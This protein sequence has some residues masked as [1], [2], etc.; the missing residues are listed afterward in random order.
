MQYALNLYNLVARASQRSSTSKQARTQRALVQCIFI[1]H[2]LVICC[3][4]NSPKST[5]IP[6]FQHPFLSSYRHF[7]YS[8]G[9]LLSFSLSRDPLLLICFVWFSQFSSFSLRLCVDLCVAQ[10][11]KKELNKYK[12]GVQQM[13]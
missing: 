5:M 9:P 13:Q 2:W 12:K 7:D 10:R 1:L 6:S 4:S 3:W 11:D 8:I